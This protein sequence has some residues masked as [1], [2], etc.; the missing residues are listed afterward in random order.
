[1]HF[2]RECV[3]LLLAMIRLRWEGDFGQGCVRAR[4]H[5]RGPL[6]LWLI[7]GAKQGAAESKKPT[8]PKSKPAPRAQGG[9]GVLQINCV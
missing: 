1:M 8:T 2:L 4:E 5:G 7:F 3:T 6:K 9:Y